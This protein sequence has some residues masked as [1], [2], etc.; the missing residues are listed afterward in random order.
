MH[1]R[2]LFFVENKVTV[3][4]R[5]LIRQPKSACYFTHFAAGEIFHPTTSDFTAKRF[6]ISASA[7]IFHC[8]QR[9]ID[10]IWG[11]QALYSVTVFSVRIIGYLTIPWFFDIIIQTNDMYEEA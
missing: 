3:R 10:S 8:C 11:S 5:Q 2:I 4:T 9:L 1:L 7:G 6:H